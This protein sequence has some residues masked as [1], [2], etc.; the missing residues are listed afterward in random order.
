LTYVSS[1]TSQGAYNSSTGVWSVGSV[2]YGASPLT[3][4]IV[5]TVTTAATV[6]NT[7]TIT[8][9]SQVDTNPN[10]NTASATVTPVS[11]VDLVVA[12]SVDNPIPVVGQ[13]VTFTITLGNYGPA[14]AT[15]VIGNDLLPAG[16]TFVSYVASQGTYNATTGVWTVGSLAANANPVTLT[17]VAH[18]TAQG[19]MT[20]TITVSSAQ[21]ESDPSDNTASAIVVATPASTPNDNTNPAPK[22]SKYNYLGR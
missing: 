11:Q 9:L 5:T 19:L 20:N 18:I 2:N 13:N 1:T 15:N 8:A 7:A 12:K 14:N 22:P 3:L 10:N 21:P 6:T 17:V 16:M 4:T